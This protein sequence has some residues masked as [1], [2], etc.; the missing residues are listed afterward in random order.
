MQLW[1]K[2]DGVGGGGAETAQK[3]QKDGGEDNSKGGAAVRTSWEPGARVVQRG[4]A[5][6][7]STGYC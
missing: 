2:A 1:E 5:A 6:E 7:Q 4:G 3:N